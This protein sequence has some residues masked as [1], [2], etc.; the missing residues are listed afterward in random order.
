[1]MASLLDT[2]RRSLRNSRIEIAIF[3]TLFTTYSY[4]H[5]GGG[6][7]N[8]SRFAQVRSIVEQ[9]QFEINDYVVYRFIPGSDGQPKLRRLGVPPG[10]PL[11]HIVDF[12]ISGDLS[13]YE[14]RFYP[15][16]PPG[17]V[18][19]AVPAY[20]AICRVER[21]L[22]ID[23]DDWWP[24][25]M[26]FYLTTVLS[27]GLP[28]ALGGVAFYRISL[29]LFPSLA[30]WTH[31]A[32]TITFG[33]GTLMLPFATFLFDHDT[34]AVLS[35][36]AFWLLLVEKEGR[37]TSVR[38]AIVLV[39]AGLL[40]GLTMVMNYSSVI[41]VVLLMLYAVWITWPRWK[42][43][44]FLAGMVPPIVFLAWYHLVCFGGVSANAYT[45]Q[46]PIFQDKERLFFGMFGFPQFDVIFKLLFSTHRGLFFTSPVLLLSCAGL[47]FMAVRNQKREEL[48]LWIAISIGYLLMNSSYNHWNAG[49][50][51]GP[52]YLIPALPF[53]SLPLAVVFRIL[54]RTTLA[55]AIFSGLIM[56]LATAVDPQ[57]A[58]GSQNPLTQYIIPLLRGET[59]EIVP[60][61]ISVRGPV[62]ANSLG[63]YESLLYPVSYP[64]GS[65]QQW[66]SFNLG[67]FFWAGSLA[68]LTPLF[69]L[70]GLE[71]GVIWRWSRPRATRL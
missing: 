1:M 71:L 5:P 59:L 13:L 8:N 24:L 16:K 58:A 51:I 63:V 19:A 38:S 50:S 32:A 69:C 43:V 11:A 44:F 36:F 41:S 42:I 17:A 45:Y 20:L 14:G 49:W 66:N 29:R 39:L 67:E 7:N 31:A 37:F 56:L 4:F 28:A 60:L 48:V 12:G 35:L 34:V 64:G 25:T 30:V 65:Q 2:V 18:L 57:P 61:G 54:P 9:G 62:S 52:R 27:V 26:N 6:W 10:T 53:L 33:L 47:W 21:A 40:T 70:L 22:G 15:N 55:V 23:P 46:N 3:F 68:S